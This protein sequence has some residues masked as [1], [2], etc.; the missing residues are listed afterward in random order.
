M[1]YIIFNITYAQ[2]AICCK[3]CFLQAKQERCS[4]LKDV[5][6]I[7]KPIT[8]IK[9]EAYADDLLAQTQQKT[10]NIF[11]T[12]LKLPDYVEEILASLEEAGYEAYVVGGCVRVHVCIA[13]GD[14][15]LFCGAENDSYGDE[16][17][18]CHCFGRWAARGGNHVS[19]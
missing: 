13:R 2:V 8:I 3:R 9:D 12:D 18:D 17:W 6:E 10:L 14:R 1:P 16:T 11:L 7:M 15:R 4:D 5:K 19:H